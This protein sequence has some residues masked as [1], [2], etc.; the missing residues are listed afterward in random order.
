HWTHTFA[1][2]S[3]VDVQASSD[4]NQRTVSSG[5]KDRLRT[6][7][8]AAQYTVAAGRRHALVIGGG[9][10]LSDDKFMRAP[11]TSFLDPES[12]TLNL[13]NLFVQDEITLDERL[14]LT[15]GLKLEHNSFTGLEYLPDA[16]LAWQVSPE[17]LW[18][19]AVS[20]AVRTPS[21]F[22]RDIRNPGLVAGGP[23]FNS[24]YLTAFEL[25]YRGQP[26]VRLTLSASAFYHVYDD[27]RTTESPAGALFPL[28]IRNGMEGRTYGVELW[29]TYAVA[30]WWQVS[31]GLTTLRK[32][33]RLKDG[34]RD[35]F[36][37]AAAGADP[38]YQAVLRS[39]MN[40]TDRLG[41]DVSL[42]AVDDLPSPAI[43]AYV[44][45]DARLA[46]LMN[47]HVELS[48][49]GFNLLNDQHGEFR[50]PSIPLREFN[51]GLQAQARLRF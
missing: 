23:D 30:D 14:R 47:E 42:R 25:G 17:T 19:A 31:G 9:Y 43:P 11:G 7:D 4:T 24:E 6:Y 45:A 26:T 51:R 38:D 29:G 48:L 20:R 33:L 50:N 5:I 44:E 35:I 21:R 36:G 3:L 13:G 22:D 10:R 27:L 34:V 2:G 49:L 28:V 39:R 15:L 16:R 12:S 18:W 40:I 8:L 1:G 46:W 41:L 32:E 37:V